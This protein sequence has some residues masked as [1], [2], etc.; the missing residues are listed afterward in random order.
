MAEITNE[1]ISEEVSSNTFQITAAAETCE[2][3]ED[4]IG[5]AHV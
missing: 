5:R 4:Q 3:I 2:T 1:F